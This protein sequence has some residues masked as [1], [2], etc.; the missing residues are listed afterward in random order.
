M[1]AET[2][3][4]EIERGKGIQFDPEVVDAFLRTRKLAGSVV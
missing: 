1:S 2:T 3:Y 4:T